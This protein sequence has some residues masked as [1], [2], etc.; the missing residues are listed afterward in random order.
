MISKPSI[1]WRNWPLWS[2]EGTYMDSFA[3]EFFVTVEMLGVSDIKQSCARRYCSDSQKKST[4]LHKPKAS[5]SLLDRNASEVPQI[6]LHTPIMLEWTSDR[7]LMWSDHIITHR[8]YA[9]IP[10]YADWGKHIHS[11]MVSSKTTK[12]LTLHF[13]L[14]SLASLSLAPQHGKERHIRIKFWSPPIWSS[15]PGY[16]VPWRTFYLCSRPA[17][18]CMSPLVSSVRTRSNLHC[19]GPLIVL[20][21]RSGI[22]LWHKISYMLLIATC[23]MRRQYAVLYLDEWFVHRKVFA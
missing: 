3:V 22:W 21:S 18:A 5:M 13:Q 15:H 11:L 6:R 16:H 19:A 2:G 8:D 1:H 20:I 10:W 4:D 14:N 9:S 23:F 17:M 12:T 7:I